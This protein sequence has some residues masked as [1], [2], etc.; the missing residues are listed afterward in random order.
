MWPA[1]DVTADANRYG[2]FTVLGANGTA[3]VLVAGSYSSTALVGLPMGGIEPPTAYSLPFGAAAS[4]R[5]SRVV[6][7]GAFMV[8]VLAAGS[9]SSTVLTRVV[10]SKPPTA[11]SL[12]LGAA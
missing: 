2:T 3:Q 1:S 5:W 11:Y 7:I 4:P 12:P 10:P 6:G 8:Q 9:Y